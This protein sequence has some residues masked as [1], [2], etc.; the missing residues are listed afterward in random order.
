LYQTLSTLMHDF[1]GN[2]PGSDVPA[3]DSIPPLAVLWPFLLAA[4]IY[5]LLRWVVWGRD[6]VSA[7]TA[8]RHAFW[9][10]I[11]GW[12]ASSLQPAAN[13]GILSAGSAVRP[14]EG[15]GGIIP[16]LAWPVVG[17]LAVHAIGQLSY[18]VPRPDR[19]QAALQVRPVRDV[20][21][22]PL[23]WTV[24]AIFSAAAVQIGWTATLPGFAP[25]PYG[26]NPDPVQSYSTYGG[27]GRVPGL[28]L[29]SYLGAA[30]FV[31]AAGTW[32]VLV[33]ITRRQLEALDIQENNLLR[34]I[35]MNRLLRT[36]ATI[37]S[38]LAAIAGNHAARPD[39]SVVSGGWTNVAG[40]VNLVV[41]LV[42]LWW[43]PPRLPA[44]RADGAEPE[45][46]ESAAAA[47]PATRLSL[48]LGAALGLA[49]LAP[50][51]VALLVP[52]AV[53]G[54]PALVVA[55]AA[56]AVLV[57]TAAGEMLMQRNYGAPEAPRAWPHQP[58]SPALLSTGIASL[59]LL[60]GV[61]VVT[62]AAQAALEVPP[63]WSATAWTAGAVVLLSLLPLRAAKARQGVTTAVPGLD[64]ALRGITVYRV[65]RTLASCFTVQAGVLLL[66]AGPGIQRALNLDPLPWAGYWQAASAAGALLAAAGVVI[67]VVPVRSFARTPAARGPRAR[68]AAP[69]TGA[70]K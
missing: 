48:S 1:G 58:V 27:D 43:T 53:T 54:H 50:A 11:M 47:H 26:S 16:A 20:L 5:V 25:V 38:G 44:L 6:G 39:P 19:R 55:M 42:M 56:A 2:V 68:T 62:A 18:P 14:L 64:A 59:A 29:A 45:P 67:A 22:R 69:R 12:A 37:A 8:S 23:A 46:R 9:V 40:A 30:L 32:F 70:A 61:V 49:A 13:A 52:G 34:T 35:A 24:L 17:C 10:G 21:P 7:A 60:A 65:V 41:L 31:L 51:V 3:A 66:S 33:L 57:A 63:S 4:G 36:V 28:E 15:S